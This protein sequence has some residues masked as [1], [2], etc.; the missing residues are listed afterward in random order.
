MK[1]KLLGIIVFAAMM[2][3]S[4][5]RASTIYTFSNDASITVNGIVDSVVG[6]FVE[7]TN[8]NQEISAAFTVGGTLYSVSSTGFSCGTPVGT[9]VTALSGLLQTTISFADVLDGTSADA[10]RVLAT[11]MSNDGVFSA[12]TAVTGEVNPTPLPAAFPLFASGVGVLVLF[13]LR[14]KRKASAFIAAA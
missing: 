7:D 8:T 3:L 6:S 5:A 4:Q 2:G 9:C 14:R 13:S 11:S 12:S 1:A 10:L